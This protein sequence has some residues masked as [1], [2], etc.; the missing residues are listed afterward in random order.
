MRLAACVNIIPS[1]RSI[2]RFEGEIHDDA[3]VQL[4]IKTRPDCF[5]SVA[6]WISEHHPY[7]VPEVIALPVTGAAPAY[8]HWLLEQTSP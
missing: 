3:E 6:A 4:L 7:D 1:I 2:Y 5:E 8:L